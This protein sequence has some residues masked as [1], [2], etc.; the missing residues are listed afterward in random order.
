MLRGESPEFPLRIFLTSR[1]I[2]DMQRLQRSLE[3]SASLLCIEIPLQSSLGDIRRYI[4]NRIDGLPVDSGPERQELADTILRKS[5]GCFLW[6]RLVMDELENVYSSESIIKVLE[7]IPE[8]MRSYYERTINAMSAITLDKHIAKAVL[9]WAAT[10]ARELTADELSQALKLDINTVLPSAKSAVEGLCGQ[11]VSVDRDS[12]L[13]HL[14]H[15]TAREFLLSEAAGEFAVSKSLAHERI[16]MTCLQ[17]LSSNEMRPPRNKRL[18]AQTRA[19]ASPF[20]DYALAHFSDHIASASSE[21][22]RLLAAMDQFFKTNALSWIERLSAKGNLHPLIR[23]SKNLKSYL[24]RRAKYQSPLNSQVR[25]IDGWSVDLS[26]LVTQFGDAL[27]QNPASIHFLIPPLCPSGS[28]VYQQF[29][30]K[31][32][33]LLVLGHKAS[34]WDDCI[35]HVNFGDDGAVAVSSGESL[36][37]VG[38]I[39]GDVNLYHHR[40]CQKQAVISHQHA[41][42]RV[43]LVDKGIVS[44]TLRSIVFQNLDGTTIWE[45]KLR[46]RC[47]HLTSSDD[48]IIA[49]S[50]HGHLLKWDKSTGDLLEDQTF[51]YRNHDVD[52]PHNGLASRVPHAVSISPDMEMLALAYRGGTVC[53]WEINGP[54]FIDWARDERGRQAATVLFNPNPNI[55]LLLAIYMDHSMA[56]F[57]TWSGARV[58]AQTMSQPVGLL[59]ASCSHDGRTLVSTD[60]RG[61][62][63]IWDFESLSLLYHVGS[64][65]PSFRVLTFTSDG[66]NVVDVMDSGMRIWSPDVLVRKATEEDASI[67]DDAMSL[68][69]TEGE[70]ESRRSTQIRSLCPHPTLPVVVAG[71]ED[72]QVV[73][74]NIKGDKGTSS[75]LYAHEPAAPVTKLAVTKDR[76]AFWDGAN[77][78]QVWAAAPAFV[79]LDRLLFRIQALGLVKQLCFSPNGE[80]L[81]VATTTADCVYGLDGACI[82]ALTFDSRE[83]NIWRWFILPQAPGKSN[84]QHFSLLADGV[85]RSYVAEAFPQLVEGEPEIRLQLDLGQNITA[86]DYGAVDVSNTQAGHHQ[87]AVEVRHYSG[88]VTSSTTFLYDLALEAPPPLGAPAPNTLTP[89][90]PQLSRRCKQFVGFSKEAVAGKCSLVFIHQNSWV[91]SIDM[92]PMGRGKS[93]ERPSLFYLQHFFIPDDYLP[94]NSEIVPVKTAGDDLVFCVHG[95]LA[96]IRNGTKFQETKELE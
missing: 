71:K 90:C 62:M 15:P 50:Q 9:M 86:T 69:V 29:G 47:L 65:F 93:K 3:P 79:K 88:F 76:L 28:V 17:L 63:R 49:V 91:S 41:V 96:C 6:V 39:S 45:H 74:F 48:C 42:D 58:Q 51:P 26:R 1:M 44:C 61:N 67:S 73:S 64:Q 78:V 70:Y 27:L 25:H 92:S 82:G 23:A 7:N 84:T 16:A 57:D 77:T 60:T 68:A 38:M 12:G 95:E 59:A 81:L 32:D 18:L 37:A 13:I 46:F 40:T 94:G 19:P 11:L 35:A 33:G 5:N 8:G 43:H 80:Y 85:I 72:G 54:E 66:S 22:D 52:T 34:A 10:S 87:L 4:N 83:R 20:L 36:I 31:P 89:V 14:I 30:K 55:N 53:L 21:N 2:G 75:V 56:L 24:D